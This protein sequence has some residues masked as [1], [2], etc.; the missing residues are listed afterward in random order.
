M[1]FG[2]MGECLITGVFVEPLISILPGFAAE[3]PSEQA[4]EA[5]VVMLILLVGPVVGGN[6]LSNLHKIVA[7]T[8]LVGELVVLALIRLSLAVIAA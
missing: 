7:D 6:P 5:L 3:Q 1:L 8:N 2:C 4:W